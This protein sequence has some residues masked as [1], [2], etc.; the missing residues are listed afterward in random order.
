LPS[1]DGWQEGVDSDGLTYF[2]ELDTMTSC[3]AHPCDDDYKFLYKG[4]RRA[5]R[6]SAVTFEAVSN[7]FLPLADIAFGR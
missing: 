1:A 6:E 3:R 4:L 5:V 7:A 2:Y